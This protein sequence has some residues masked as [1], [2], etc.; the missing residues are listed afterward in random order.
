M[1][2]VYVYC[3][4][5][6]YSNQWWIQKTFSV[7]VFWYSKS[8]KKYDQDKFKSNKGNLKHILGYKIWIYWN[9]QSTLILILLNYHIWQSNFCETLPSKIHRKQARKL[10]DAQAKS[11]QAY[12]LTNPQ[13]DKLTIWLIVKLPGWKDERMTNWQSYKLTGWQDGWITI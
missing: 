5:R 11:W 10:Q 7:F 3:F 4:Q 1:T 9:W 8:S 6:W 13:A 2:R 12:K